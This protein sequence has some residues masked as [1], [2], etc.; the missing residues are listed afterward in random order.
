MKEVEKR[1]LIEE[2]DIPKLKKL[3]DEKAK[4]VSHKALQT[5][6]YAKPKYLRMR[7]ENGNEKATVT[8]KIGTY[9]DSSRDEYEME[10]PTK[11]VPMFAKIMLHLG[12]DECAYFN[13]ECWTYNYNGFR[14]D[15]TTHDYLG[16]I[17]EAEKM[18]NNKEEVKNIG[19][20]ISAV[21]EEFGLKELETEKYMAMMESMFKKALKPVGAHHV[22]KVII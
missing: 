15:L 12:F 2:K 14:I 18:T 21:F 4:I 9:K 13:S 5:I 6:L 3:L 10:I 8:L 16:T 22:L 11:D 1:S 20:D 17:F 7:W 19:R